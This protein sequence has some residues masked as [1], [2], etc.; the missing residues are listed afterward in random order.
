MRYIKVSIDTGFVSCKHEATIDVEDDAT[1]E[2]IDGYAQE[3]VWEYV[4][5]DWKEVT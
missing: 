4:H 1:E 2:E 3:L 5:V